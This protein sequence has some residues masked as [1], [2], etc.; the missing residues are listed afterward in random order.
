MWV[1]SSVTVTRG[2][3]K[4]QKSEN[5]ADVICKRSHYLN[6]GKALST[7]SRCRA[8]CNKIWSAIPLR[9]LLIWEREREWVSGAKMCA[10]S[11]VDIRLVVLPY[12][13]VSPTLCHSDSDLVYQLKREFYIVPLFW[14]P[15][16]SPFIDI[17]C[18]CDFP[19]FHLSI[20]VITWQLSEVSHLQRDRDSGIERAKRARAVF[21]MWSPQ[22]R[23]G[24]FAVAVE[25]FHENNNSF[26]SLTF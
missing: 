7:F 26:R 10:V 3:R 20:I 12:K 2:W 21:S 14:R 18:T 25:I 22:Q 6:R 15:V 17:L 16:T 24:S 9:L 11:T 23:G 13:L 8:K 5:F 19:W 1:V 4:V